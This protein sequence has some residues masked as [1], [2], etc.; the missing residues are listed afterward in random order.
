MVSVTLILEE[1]E[2]V[3]LKLL[4]IM[5]HLLGNYAFFPISPW[6]V[7]WFPSK[8][9]PLGKGLLLVGLLEGSSYHSRSYFPH[10]NTSSPQF[11][12]LLGFRAY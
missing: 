1:F 11:P 4:L 6:L 7:S 12:N 5:E 8:W 2:Y 10:F 9:P 3:A